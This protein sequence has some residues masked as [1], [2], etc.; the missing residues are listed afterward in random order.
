MKNEFLTESFCRTSGDLSC[1]FI[2]KMLVARQLF[3][4]DWKLCAVCMRQLVQDTHKALDTDRFRK[5]F[6]IWILF[7][8]IPVIGHFKFVRSFKPRLISVSNNHWN[9]AW[10]AIRSFVVEL[11][12]HSYLLNLSQLKYQAHFTLSFHLC[13]VRNGN[14][15]HTSKW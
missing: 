8:W 15:R 6:W 13:L 1:L 10:L 11:L 7:S 2:T 14:E 5:K 12:Y 4:P 9:C 3:C